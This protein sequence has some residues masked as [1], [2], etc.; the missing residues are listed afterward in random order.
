MA[1]WE[2]GLPPIWVGSPP[3][4]H[5]PMHPLS[6]FL[7]V[8]LPLA[9]IHFQVSNMRLWEFMFFLVIEGPKGAGT[10]G[11]QEPDKYLKASSTCQKCPLP[12]SA[13]Q[14]SHHI[15]RPGHGV[16]S[17]TH[18]RTHCFC[19]RVCGSLWLTQLMSFSNSSLKLVVFGFEATPWLCSGFT[20][21]GA[22]GNLGLN[23]S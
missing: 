19:F 22:L 11:G 21:G 5:S 23:L 8:N 3:K 14:A 9:K 17:S 4:Y 10:R 13:L 7:S 18:R 20:P 12:A 2:E 1:V 6:W 16:T 15:T